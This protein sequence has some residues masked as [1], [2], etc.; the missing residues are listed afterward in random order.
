MNN[1]KLAY[2]GQIRATL[3]TIDQ[4]TP[5]VWLLNKQF[6][7]VRVE[8][9]FWLLYE[10]GRDRKPTSAPHVYRH[11]VYGGREAVIDHIAS[12][13]VA[14]AAASERAS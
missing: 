7:V 14:L 2:I 6:R 12:M 3:D 4:D 11:S 13:V 8:A 5:I 10:H 1:S 9:G